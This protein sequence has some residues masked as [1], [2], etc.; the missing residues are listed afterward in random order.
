MRRSG[1]TLFHFIWLDSW[2]WELSLQPPAKHALDSWMFSLAEY[3]VHVIGRRIKRDDIQV[4]LLDKVNG[5]TGSYVDVRTCD[6][7][8]FEGQCMAGM[9]RPIE[10]N[11]NWKCEG[12]DCQ[13]LQPAAC[14]WTH[15]TCRWSLTQLNYMYM[16]KR[17]VTYQRKM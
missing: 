13:S 4:Q 15:V 2:L 9:Q 17:A 1:P 6:N 7:A 11:Y 5:F 14:S 12:K 3:V 10:G 16:R 8:A